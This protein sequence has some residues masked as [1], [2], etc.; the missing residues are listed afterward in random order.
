MRT[1]HVRVT[2]KKGK[3]QG[4][5]HKLGGAFTVGWTTPEGICLGAWNALS[6]CVITML[7]GG[8][9][10]WEQEAGFTTIHCPDPKGI[11]FELRRIEA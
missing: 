11:T 7:C 1:M 4:G 5:I 6:P 2:V 8:N 3:C 10:P 9:F